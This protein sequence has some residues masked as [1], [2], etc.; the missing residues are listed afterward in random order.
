MSVTNDEVRE[1]LFRLYGV[2]DQTALIAAIAAEAGVPVGDADPYVQVKVAEM[3]AILE[4]EAEES[5]W[6]P[7]PSGLAGRRQAYVKPDQ[8]SGG[9]F[10]GWPDGHVGWFPD[11]PAAE[12]A[13]RAAKR[14]GAIW[15]V[16]VWRV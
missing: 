15:G 1:E 10:V 11:R 13:L 2:E 4:A 16:K 8:R 6:V 14:R 12:T 9:V 5:E 3:R 7:T